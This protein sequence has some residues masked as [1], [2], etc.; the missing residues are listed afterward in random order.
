VVRLEVRQLVGQPRQPAAKLEA[1]EEA[2][3]ARAEVEE[4]WV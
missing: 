3:Q 4:V 1:H 2:H